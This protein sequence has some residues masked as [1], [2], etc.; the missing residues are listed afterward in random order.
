MRSISRIAGVSINTVSK[1]LV[2]AGEGCL[3]A[4]DNFTKRMGM[5]RFTRL[6]NAHSK[7][8]QN[9]IYALAFYFIFYNFCRKHQTLGTTPVVAAGL[10]AEQHDMQWIV[11]LIDEAKPAPKKRGP[12]R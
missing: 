10:T 9:H 1:L 12:Y 7:K 8:Y 4:H 5:R 11:S 6:T 3:L 2:D